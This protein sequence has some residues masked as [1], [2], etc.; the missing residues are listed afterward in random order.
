MSL[1]PKI[2][3]MLLMGLQDL[4]FHGLMIQNI[5]PST[6]FISYDGDDLHFAD[7]TQIAN[8]GDNEP[9]NLELHLP[10]RYSFLKRH[11]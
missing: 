9:R 8:E 5:Q 10:Y 1:G 7:I 2:V 11:H 3:K 4:K 6:V